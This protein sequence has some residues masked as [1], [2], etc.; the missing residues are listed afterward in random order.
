MMLKRD[1]QKII[2]RYGP[3]TIKTAF[4]KGK[5][6]RSKPEFDDCVRIAKE[7]NISVQTVYLEINK[8]I[9]NLNPDAY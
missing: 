1:F 3:V 7:N 4:Y 6:L 9:A 2:T 5:R 8:L